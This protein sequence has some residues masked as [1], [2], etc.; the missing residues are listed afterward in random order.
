MN[1]DAQAVAH[2]VVQTWLTQPPDPVSPVDRLRALIAAALE[3]AYASGLA[4]ATEHA[5]AR[6]TAALAAVTTPPHA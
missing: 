5:L 2:H 1:Y 4:D 6:L 3:D